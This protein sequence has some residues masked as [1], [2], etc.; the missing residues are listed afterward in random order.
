MFRTLEIALSC[1]TLD[2][3]LQP[4]CHDF[5]GAARTSEKMLQQGWVASSPCGRLRNLLPRRGRSNTSMPDSGLPDRF[6]QLC[7]C[8]VWT[9]VERVVMMWGRTG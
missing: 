9:D 2:N 7:R 6:G 3:N 4:V 8:Q 1:S 5:R